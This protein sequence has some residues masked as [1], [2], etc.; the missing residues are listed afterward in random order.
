VRGAN[1]AKEYTKKD[2]EAL[3]KL[4]AS[5]NEDIEVGE[6]APF[7]QE[8]IEQMLLESMGGMGFE[9]GMEEM[10]DPN[11]SLEA[12]FIAR[13]LTGRGSMKIH[14]LSTPKRIYW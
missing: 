9:G 13:N 10:E 7:T 2:I 11:A 5:E 4:A 3:E 12:S 14:G 6:D 8:E 1:V